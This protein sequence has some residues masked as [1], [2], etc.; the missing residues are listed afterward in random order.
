MVFSSLHAAIYHMRNKFSRW[1]Y[2]YNNLNFDF[3]VTI[4]PASQLE[5]KS[6]NVV[7]D[8]SS[9]EKDWELVP[10]D[11]GWGWLILAVCYR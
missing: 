3:T 11:G 8:R 5:R 10:P 7:Q 1:H 6:K 9:P 2:Y 4:I